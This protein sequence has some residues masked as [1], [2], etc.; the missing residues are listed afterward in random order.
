MADPIDV[1][2]DGTHEHGDEPGWTERVSFAFFDAPSRF[3]GIA[4]VEFLPLERRAEGALTLFVSEGVVAT[5]LAREE[6]PGGGSSVGRIMLDRHEA[7]E[8]W[9]LRCKDVALLFPSQRVGGGARGQRTGAASQIDLDVSFEAWTPPAGS[10]TR[11]KRVDELGFVQVSSS[12]HFEQAGRYSG[13]ARVGGRAATIEGSGVRARSW[14]PLD[15]TARH[16]ERWFAV[17]FGP[18]LA[19]GLRS[20]SIG[21]RHL[22]HGWV[23]RDGEMRDVRALHAQ[24][25]QDGRGVRALMLGV[26]DS[27]GDRYDITGETLESIPLREGDVHIRQAMTRYALDGREA[28]GLAE[29]LES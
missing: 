25:E 8:K 23:H 20:V 3:G 14:G 7:L 12:G 2:D 18:R 1:R 4:R 6:T 26:T 17:A 27:A 24:T 11:D 28:V 22:Q 21:D 10:V 19:F 13:R 9:R 16:V 15:R 29:Y 5:V